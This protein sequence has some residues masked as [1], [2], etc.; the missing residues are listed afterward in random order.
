MRR[1][2][3]RDLAR[4]DEEIDQLVAVEHGKAQRQRRMGNIVAADVEQPGDRIGR[5]QHRGIG[6][7]RHE[8]RG[9]AGALG[10]GAFA[11]ETDVVRHDRRARRRRPVGPDR[12]HRIAVERDEFAARLL[13]GGAI[14][15]HLA[16]R[17]QPRIV[18][19][20]LARL[21]IG[22]DP[23]GRRMVADMPVIEELAVDLGRGLE[24]VT[25]VDEDRGA[26]PEDDRQP[27][28]AGKAGQPGKALRRF[29]DI[30]ALIFVRPRYQEPVDRAAREFRPQ[31]R[32]PLRRPFP[33]D[34]ATVI[35]TD[36]LR[37]QTL[38]RKS[39]LAQM[40]R[41]QSLENRPER[42]PNYPD[43]RWA[44]GWVRILRLFLFGRKAYLLCNA[45][46][47]TAYVT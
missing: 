23:R 22:L 12:I 3:G 30:F 35:H 4:V 25:T 27:G 28:R 41:P 36:L 7:L 37:Q 11:G 43:M 33:A 17:M 16:Q 40:P 5:R 39:L 6:A 34:R 13:G 14:A 24:G 31:P 19:K 20:R 44:N 18:A 8:A 21:E 45:K 38:A 10:R 47:K 1:E 32:E 46:E 9:D 29:G 2:R 26:I 42:P 15:R